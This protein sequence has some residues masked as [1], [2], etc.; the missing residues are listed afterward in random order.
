MRTLSVLLA[1]VVLGM[2][3]PLAQG[4]VA[5]EILAQIRDDD[6]N[7]LPRGLSLRERQIYRLPDL[8]RLPAA[9]P[10]VPVRA[11]AEYEP[12]DGLLVRWGSFNSLLTEMTV[13]VTTLDTSARMFIVVSGTTQQNSAASTL[14]T[15]G[16]NMARVVFI[17]APTNSVW[18]RD[19]GPRYVNQ[20]GAR[21]IVDHVY[22]RPRPLDDAIPGVIAQLWSEPKY[23]IPLT[24]GGGN[25]HLFGT[26][27]AYM[28]E[29]ILNENPGLTQQQ[30]LD[31]YQAYQGLNVTL[32]P[33]FPTSFDSTQHID[34]WMLPVD[35]DEVIVS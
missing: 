6:P 25:F 29:L 24:H 34:M 8:S 21:A 1:W 19:Y 14:Q 16:A 22:N 10:P 33:A 5:P 12:N 17:Q 32:L 7:P 2:G 35:D 31:Y 23:D 9:P 15:A 18:M 11:T 30:I 20:N 27:D 28:T 13:A 3:A 26:R 4:V